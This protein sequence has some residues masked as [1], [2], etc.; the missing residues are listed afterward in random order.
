MRTVVVGASNS[1]VRGGVVQGMIDGGVDV[2]ANGSLGHSQATI[3][4]FRLSDGQY[5]RLD[6]DHLVVEIATNEQ[7]ALRSS[8]AN[9][10]TIGAILDWTVRWCAER[11]IGLTLVTMP[12]S[13][14]YLHAGDLRRF[15]VNRFL[16][17]YAEDN[18]LEMFDGYEWLEQ[19]M[20][21]RGAGLEE[22]FE[23]SA[24]MQPEIAHAFGMR[25][26][27]SMR[28]VAPQP[29]PKLRTAPNF[30]YVP[31]S[32]AP[33]WTN[34]DTV[35]RSTSLGTAQLLRLTTQRSFILELKRGSV[36]GTV[37]NAAGSTAVLNIDG[38]TSQ[39]KRMDGHPGAKLILT[40]WG[41]RNPARVNGRTILRALPVEY[42]PSLEHNHATIW[43]P[44]SKNA[45]GIPCVELAGLVLSVPPYTV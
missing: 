15:G 29:V 2:I 35:E 13:A 40:A 24:H 10:E 1:L 41:L 5:G 8:L 6:F 39:A 14:S 18:R 16:R 43:R 36:V 7:I 19:W 32:S 21:D 22:S 4:P 45:R 20:R 33:D 26:A 25:I 42:L 31:M 23:T 3:L 44:L 11:D 12:E 37:H 28:S 30:E 9:F 27:A 34:A 38:A 17:G